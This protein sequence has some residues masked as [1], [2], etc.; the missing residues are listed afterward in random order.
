MKYKKLLIMAVMSLIGL[1]SLHAKED[2]TSQY[3]VNADLS[4]VGETWQCVQYTDWQLASNAS[5]VN[6]VEFWAGNNYA[7]GKFKFYQEVTLPAGYY[8]L[9]V[10]AFYRNGQGGD[11][12]NNDNAWIFAGTK[13]QNVM[14]LSGMS[15]LSGYESGGIDGSADLQHASN[16]FQLGNYSN[17]FD[18]LLETEQTIEIGFAGQNFSNNSCNSL[19]YSYGI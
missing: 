14:A 6:V 11:G 4:A 13:T 16:A 3:L 2:V 5:H 12:T 18:F 8:R 10:N 7:E 1:C 9:A 17:E 19:L 15:E